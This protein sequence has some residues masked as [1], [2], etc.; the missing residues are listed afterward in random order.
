MLKTSFFSP[1]FGLLMAA[2]LFPSCGQATPPKD[3]RNTVTRTDTIFQVKYDTVTVSKTIAESI[4]PEN[5]K[6]NDLL[7][8]STFVRY[9]EGANKTLLDLDLA[10]EYIV[11]LNKTA[12]KDSILKQYKYMIEEFIVWKNFRP[13]VVGKELIDS[14]IKTNKQYFQDDDRF[15]SQHILPALWYNKEFTS[16]AYYCG[17]SL[18]GSANSRFIACHVFRNRDGRRLYLNDIIKK[19]GREEFF[20]IAYQ[21]WEKQRDE[22]RWTNPFTKDVAI[23]DASF[24]Y[25][26]D[27]GDYLVNYGLKKNFY[28]T[29]EGM[30]FSYGDEVFAYGEEVIFNGAECGQTGPLLPYER[31]KHLL[32]INI[33]H[34]KVLTEVEISYE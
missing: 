12:L 33:K 11:P 10:Y 7:F 27:F 29:P 15:V 6:A 25:D 5:P 8:K 3:T 18:G 4:L 32:Q 9:E 23:F 16:I 13:D 21:E 24:Q 30:V 2:A 20:R 28:F 19:Q 26:A 1:L 31:I 17:N 14:V 34:L 22:M